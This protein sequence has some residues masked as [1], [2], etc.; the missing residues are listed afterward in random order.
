MNNLTRYKNFKFVD[1]VILRTRRLKRWLGSF[2]TLV[3]DPSLVPAPTGLLTN[4]YNSS[5]R[6]NFLLDSKA[7]GLYV[8]H[9][10]TCRQILII[11][12][13]IKTKN[14]YEKA[15]NNCNLQRRRN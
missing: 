8:I 14:R 15:I 4:V 3:E 11:H 2:A 1:F 6:D 13:K 12:I 10:Y 7:A 5:S 9:I